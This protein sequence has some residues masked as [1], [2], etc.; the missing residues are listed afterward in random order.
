[1]LLTEFTRLWQY[2]AEW[3]RVFRRFDRDHSGTIEKR[4]LADAMHSFGYRLSSHLLSLLQH[5]Y[6]NLHDLLPFDSSY[7]Y[8]ASGAST[9]YGPT[10]GITFDRFVRACVTVKT[11]TEAFQRFA[12]PF[13]QISVVN[14]SQRADFNN[15]G[16]AVF[17]YEEFMKVITYVAFFTL[18]RN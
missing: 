10:P 7:T 17:T 16:R 5:K 13:L 2:I 8:L 18:A 1:M 6:G 4:E 15:D 11:L 9:A 12:L 3:E 14:V